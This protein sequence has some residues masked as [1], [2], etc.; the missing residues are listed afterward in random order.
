MTIY[1]STGGYADLSADKS[2]LK[3]IEAGIN[4]IELSGGIYST[5]VIENLSKLEKKAKFQI[6]NYFPPPKIP[7]VLNLASQNREI[8]NLTLDHIDYVLECCLKL[9]ATYYS[10]HAGFLCDLKVN[11]LGQKIKK[12]E[13]YDRE[14]SINLFLE[15]IVK[16]SRKAEDKGIKIMIEN[17]VLSQ[18]S[19]NEFKE[20]PLLMCDANEC[21]KIIKQVPKNVKLLL[22]VA[23]LKVSAKSLGFDP[24]DMIKKCNDCV[25]G[26][27]LSDNNGLSDTNEPFLEN[28]WFLKHLRPDLNYYSIEVYGESIDRIKKLIS[29][30]QNNLSKNQKKN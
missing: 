28:A 3:L 13:L 18:K 26:Y 20:N 22:D 10:F 24:I 14:K 7:F 12:R 21:I 30:V 17:N 2:S 19:K 25:G 15:R 16:I 1:I 11:E 9:G 4:S 23:H 5:N 6:H 29:L 27:H 8:S